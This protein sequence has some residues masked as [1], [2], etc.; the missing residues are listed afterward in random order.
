[1][2]DL[3]C[4]LTNCKFNENSNCTANEI[5]VDGD[6]ICTSFEPTKKSAS[7]ADSLPMPL[8][9]HSVDVNCCADCILKK[10]NKCI[11]N[12]ITVLDEKGNKAQADCST[13]MPK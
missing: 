13:F 11:A 8:V 4:K 1:M 3:K 9:N 6:A 2:I 12:G 7:K 10:N 5:S